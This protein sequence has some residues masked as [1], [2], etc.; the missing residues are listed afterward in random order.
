MENVWI[1]LGIVSAFSSAMVVVCD[2]LG[3]HYIDSTL[4]GVI[5]TTVSLFM[6]MG[7]QLYFNN[8]S[9]GNSIDTQVMPYILLS[10]LFTAISY[11]CYYIIMSYTSVS[12]AASLDQCTI[13]FIIYL[14][15]VFLGETIALK[16]VIGSIFLILGMAFMVL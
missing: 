2:K 4:V 11:V 14:A 1:L 8:F 13:I 6:L 16:S 10:A 15:M 3:T 12:K 5:Q 7:M 9:V